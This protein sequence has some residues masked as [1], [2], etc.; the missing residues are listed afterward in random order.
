MGLIQNTSSSRQIAT[1][2]ENAIHL[3]TNYGYIVYVFEAEHVNIFLIPVNNLIKSGEK[4][5]DICKQTRYFSEWN[6]TNG[7]YEIWN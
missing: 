4:M 5:I 1:I 2:R 3:N 6:I 7:K